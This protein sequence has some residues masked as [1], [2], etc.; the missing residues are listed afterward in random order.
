MANVYLDENNL[1]RFESEVF[2]NILEQM[3]N[4]GDLEDGGFIS[5]LG[6]I[7]INV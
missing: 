2:Q 5:V 4:L 7:E 3:A 6:S 1:T